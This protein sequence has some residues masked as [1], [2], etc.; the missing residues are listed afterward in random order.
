MDKVIDEH[1]N[2]ENTR[3][4][5]A[6][7]R[8]EAR[9]A[10]LAAEKEKRN[11]AATA[12]TAGVVRGGAPRRNARPSPGSLARRRKWTAQEAD[13]LR[14][15]VAKYGAGNWAQI[16]QDPQFSLLRQNNRTN[17]NLKDKWRVLT[18]SRGK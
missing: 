2:S 7:Q 8:M 1:G 14:N 15:A 11:G 4:P 6:Q 10:R 16:L 17:V 12:P 18:K 5:T 13:T 9:E 3:P